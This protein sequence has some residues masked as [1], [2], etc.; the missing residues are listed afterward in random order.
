MHHLLQLLREPK[1]RVHSVVSLPLSN[2]DL[3]G[4]QASG[5]VIEAD[6][7]TI[8]A[9]ARKLTAILPG[10]SPGTIIQRGANGAEKATR[11][12]RMASGSVGDQVDCLSSLHAMSSSL[13][14]VSAMP[15]TTLVLKCFDHLLIQCFMLRILLTHHLM[16]YGLSQATTPVPLRYSNLFLLSHPYGSSHICTA[17]HSLLQHTPDILEY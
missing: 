12:C 3:V 9:H 6:I 7:H 11:Q 14:S 2:T 10:V 15:S 16:G 1:Q 17:C 13:S 5:I 8:L 4:T